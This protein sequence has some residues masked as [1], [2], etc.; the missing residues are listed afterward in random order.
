MDFISYLFRLTLKFWSFFSRRYLNPSF[1]RFTTITV[2][3]VGLLGLVAALW[4]SA[5]GRNIY[6]SWAGG[7]YS[8]FYIA[9]KILN[10]HPPSKLYD[11]GL[12]SKLLHSLLPKI[13]LTEALPYINPPFF[14][15]IFKP[16]SRFPYMVSYSMWMLVSVIMY[17]FGFK[18]FWKTLDSMPQKTSNVAL[19]LALSFEPFLYETMFGG[20]SSAVGFFAIALSFYFG[21]LKKDLISGLLLGI[22]LYKPTF[23]IVIL[24]MIVISRSLKI[25]LG[26]S[27]SSVILLLLSALTVGFETCI[28]YMQFLLGLSTTI[29]RGEVIFRTWKYVDI[30]S[31]GQLLLGTASPIVL[32]LI[33]TASLIPFI[34]LIKLW[35]KLNSLNKSSQELL[36]ASAITLTIIINLHF[37]IYDSVILVLSILLTV[38]VLYR[39]STG[40]NSAELTPGFKALLFS[41][42]ILPWISQHMARTSG[43]QLFTLAIVIM[44]IYQISLVRTYSKLSG[45][46]AGRQ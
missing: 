14:A 26:F 18:L 8:C 39:T 40:Q 15:L 41:I 36:K 35:W 44:G 24:P 7:D 42:Y 31:F 11:F 46:E 28:K 25:L 16:L 3:L 29:L 4:T 23:L 19:L 27:I 12:Q 37:A 22:C 9:G 1:I 30:F 34:F 2:I 21:Q 13:S 43:F 10:E 32:I 17:I 33:V 45:L 20:N 6:G 5:G 38:N